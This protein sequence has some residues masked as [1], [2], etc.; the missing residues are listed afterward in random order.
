MDFFGSVRWYI[1][2]NGF[3]ETLHQSG[4]YQ[5]GVMSTVLSG[6]IKIVVGHYMKHFLKQPR[7]LFLQKYFSFEVPEELQEEL[8]DHCKEFDKI[9]SLKSVKSISQIM[10]P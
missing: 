5:A 8:I 3:K 7:D 9:I 1:S 4:M 10:N 2:Q 6:N